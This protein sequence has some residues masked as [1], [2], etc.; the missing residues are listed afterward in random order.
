MVMMMV[1]MG[2]LLNIDEL[3]LASG[4]RR[5][6]FHRRKGV[7]CTGIIDDDERDDGAA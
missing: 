2:D 6:L 5:D 7:C 4:L 3:Q 1:V